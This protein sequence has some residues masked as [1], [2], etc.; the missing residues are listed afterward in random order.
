MPDQLSKPRL[1]IETGSHGGRVLGF[2]LDS[3]GSVLLTAAHDKTAR[4]WSVPTLRS[5]GV[6][7]P[8]LREGYDGQLYAAALS[9]DGSMG[10][11][12][13]FSKGPLTVHVFDVARCEIV[14]QVTV[15]EVVEELVMALRFSPERD[16]LVAGTN[17]R[18]LMVI[19]VADW[20]VIGG[21]QAIKESVSALDF[22]PDGER[23][24]VLSD[25]GVVRVYE[26]SRLHGAATPERQDK[27][28]AGLRGSSVRFSPDG[29][30]LALGF[31][32]GGMEV[33]EERDLSL[34]WCRRPEGFC[35]TPNFSAVAWCDDGEGLLVSGDTCLVENEWVAMRGDASGGAAD[36]WRIATSEAMKANVG[37]VADLEP[38]RLIASRT[39]EIALYDRDG[40]RLAHVLPP[41]GDTRM[42]YDAGTEAARTFRVSYDGTVAEWSFGA[43]SRAIRFDART[44]TLQHDP[45]PRQAGL[46]KWAEKSGSAAVRDWRESK[47]PV[48]KMPRDTLVP[49]VLT[50]NETCHAVDVDRAHV[51]LG[52]DF[53]LYR[54][55]SADGAPAAHRPIADGAYRVKQSPDGRLA[56]AALLDGTVRWFKL[57]NE[58]RELLSVFVTDEPLPRWVAFTPDGYYAAGAG[59][60]DLI[61]WHIDRGPEHSAGFFAASDF[62]ERFHR[63]DVVKRV[64]ATSDEMEA[65]RQADAARGGEPTPPPQEQVATLREEQPPIVNILAPREG[66]LLPADGILVIAAEVRTLAAKRVQEV[67]VRVDGGSAHFDPI[68]NPMQL[69]NPAPGEEAS[70]RLL[71]VTMGVEPRTEA[72]VEVF[73]LDETRRP[74][75]PAVVKLRR[76]QTPQTALSEAVKPRLLAVLLGVTNYADE[77]LRKAVTFASKDAQDIARLL[78]KQSGVLYREVVC[79]C[80]PDNATRDA[81]F[82]ELEWLEKTSTGLD[83]ALLF[84]AGHGMTWKRSVY[85]FLLAGASLNAPERQG[86]SG[87]ELIM[88]METVGAKRLVMLDTCYAGAA[89]QPLPDWAPDADRMMNLLRTAGVPVFGAT[90]ANARAQ[91]R[92]KLRNGVFTHALQ[93]VLSPPDRALPFSE[94]W[95]ELRREV[96]AATGQRQDASFLNAGSGADLALLAGRSG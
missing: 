67:L 31:E 17:K 36:E 21:D 24:A 63:P 85:Y 55:R 87:P 20:T 62:R 75:A 47:T 83:T 68:G 65:L 53:N 93:K 2:D 72:A 44:L 50:H 58:L 79:H 94:L 66:A 54:F 51:L 52:A 71:Q 41:N 23:L 5:L 78:D 92:S 57:D 56:V 96:G 9:K 6:L 27:A 22:S 42:D 40:K 18:G 15:N 32:D 46:A 70:L 77:S 89:G 48:L 76:P 25:D 14:R 28:L 13:G 59:A 37:F 34:R 12:S 4:L 1:R 91:E 29:S 80:L 35:G 11:V 81:V 39:G 26:K 45:L 84:L 90:L 49:L 43:H 8:S 74:S 19:S 64:L 86:L 38:G 33:R 88:R 3:S 69:A 10:A 30:A 61:G 60:D 16:L 95:A 73:V 82:D 7:R